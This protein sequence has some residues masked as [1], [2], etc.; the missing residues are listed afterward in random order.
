MND[1]S[2]DHTVFQTEEDKQ[3]LEK[4]ILSEVYDAYSEDDATINGIPKGIVFPIQWRL[5]YVVSIL[6]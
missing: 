2:D 1:D 3:Q 6:P 4:D 5:R